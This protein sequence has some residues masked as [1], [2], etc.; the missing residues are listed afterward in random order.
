M[1]VVGDDHVVA[2]IRRPH[3]TS[4]VRGEYPQSRRLRERAREMR[5]S[6]DDLGQQFDCV[7]LQLRI[8]TRRS[9]S[10]AGAE[11]EEERTPGRGMKQDWQQRLPAVGEQRRT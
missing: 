10:E 9:R 4:R 5:G 11:A 3:E 2:L 1:K 7:D 8:F 6:S